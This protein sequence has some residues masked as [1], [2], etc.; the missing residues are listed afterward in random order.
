MSILICDLEKK[1]ASEALSPRTREIL[2]ILPAA[3]NDWPSPIV[4]LAD[5]EKEIHHFIGNEMDRTKLKEVISLI[6]Y[7]KHAWEAESLSQLIEIYSYYDEKKSLKEI[8]DEIEKQ[9][10]IT[11]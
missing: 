8:F 2:T 3:I 1:Q 11:T 5:F 7:S 6:E 9:F 4:H 10:Q